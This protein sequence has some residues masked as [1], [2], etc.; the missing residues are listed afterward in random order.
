MFLNLFYLLQ[1]IF[2]RKI[3]CTV[4]GLNLKKIFAKVQQL[5][6]ENT[7]SEKHSPDCALHRR[8]HDDDKWATIT[9]RIVP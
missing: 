5:E 6:N 7:P 4:I 8:P 2:S 9:Q 1:K 3:F